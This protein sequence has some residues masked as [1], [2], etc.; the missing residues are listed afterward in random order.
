[1]R[2]RLST[3]SLAILVV[4]LLAVPAMAFPSEDCIPDDG[5]THTV[6][7]ESDLPVDSKVGE[8]TVQAFEADPI[9]ADDPMGG[10]T[11]AAQGG[12]SATLTVEVT[13]TAGDLAGPNGEVQNGTGE[14]GDC[15]EVYV[16]YIVRHKVQ[17]CTTVGV[18]IEPLGMGGGGTTQQCWDQWVK[19]KQKSEVKTVCPC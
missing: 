9:S 5:A 14:L 3:N 6:T 18:T 2:N 19:R 17:I 7:F 8:S 15:I 13:N 4:T 10:G 12:G 1:M 11:V 16:T